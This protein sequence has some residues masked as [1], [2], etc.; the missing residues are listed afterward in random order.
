MTDE[1]PT[2]ASPR[3]WAQYD[4]HSV[5]LCVQ[6]RPDGPIGP[7]RMSPEDV[8]ALVAGLATAVDD[9]TAHQ[10]LIAATNDALRPTAGEDGQP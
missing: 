9:F 3:V 2:T 5:L 10:E 7:L 1:S 4:D 6:T 8:L